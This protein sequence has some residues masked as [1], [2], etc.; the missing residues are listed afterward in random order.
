MHAQGDELLTLFN[1]RWIFVCCGNAVHMYSQKSRDLV[2]V[3]EQHT[4]LVTGVQLNAN[5]LFQVE[6]VRAHSRVRVCVRIMCVSA[7]MCT[8]TYVRHVGM[9]LYVCFLCVCVVYLFCSKI[10][11]NKTHCESLTYF[12]VHTVTTCDIKLSLI[13]S[14]YLIECDTH[15]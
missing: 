4:A 3:L 15:T 14:L 1:S 8:H 10:H 7:C 12:C 11:Y 6:F 13:R 2:H 9:L 5:N